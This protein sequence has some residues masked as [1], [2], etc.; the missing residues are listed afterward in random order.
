MD[1][2]KCIFKYAKPTLRPGGPVGPG[3]PE[4]PGGPCTEQKKTLKLKQ[5][6]IS[7]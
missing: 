5:K 1:A 2:H 4:A 3:S 6:H 7:T